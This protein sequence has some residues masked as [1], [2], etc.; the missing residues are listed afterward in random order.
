MEDV[1]LLICMYIYKNR[2]VIEEQVLILNSNTA[3]N[4]L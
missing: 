2:L 1:E 3:L 4:D